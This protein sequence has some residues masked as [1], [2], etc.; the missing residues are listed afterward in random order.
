MRHVFRYAFRR[1]DVELALISDTH[2]PE[3]ATSIPEPFREKIAAADH[4]IHA[5]D[6]EN[7]TALAEVRELAGDLTAVHGNV[8]PADFGRP[9]VA[10]VTV[11]DVTFVV[12][13]GT[14]N[15]VEAAV[16]GHDG[17]VMTME[18][19]QRA[20]ADTAR[21]RTRAWDGTN[22]IGIGGHIHTVVD[23]EYEGVRVLNPGT[24]TGANEDD[25]PTMMTVDVSDGA[26]E[27][28]VHE[29]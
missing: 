4:T 21:V 1:A 9:A 25:D 11:E 19:W 12:T 20:I 3:R 27:V 23:E 17:M 15:L 28:T 10:E 29:A 26:V 8:D 14:L 7:E 13:H 6:F 2:I 22:V 5:G 24:V 16:Y 18:D